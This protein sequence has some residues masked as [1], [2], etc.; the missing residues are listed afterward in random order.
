MPDYRAPG[1]YIEE[2]DGGSAPI[3]GASTA[4]AAF[5]GFTSSYP[6][7]DEGDPKALT[8]RKINNW[9]QFETLYGGTRQAEG[10][11]MPLAVYGWF[12]N[13]GGPAYIV[14]V[15]HTEEDEPL[16]DDEPE[17][18]ASSGDE[19][20]DEA[21]SGG[22]AT[23]KSV[24]PADFIG[25]ASARTGISGLVVAE[26]AT[27]V[28]CP[29]LVT[30]FGDEDG[31]L[32]A[33]GLLGF[34]AV[35]DA[36]MTQTANSKNAMAILDAP[37]GMDPNRVAAWRNDE[38]SY[39]NAFAALY[40]PWIKVANP[41]YQSDSEDRHTRSPIVTIPPS[42][43][44]AGAWA[45]NDG[46]RGPWKSP[47][48]EVVR[49]ALGLESQ[50][51]TLDQEDLNPIGVNC[52]RPFG[53]EGTKIWGARTLAPAADQWRYIA[54]RRLFNYVETSI[55][56]GTNWVVFEPNDE[57]LWARVSRTITAFLNGVWMQGGLAGGTADQAFYVKC[58][59]ETN[60]QDSIDQ[61]RLV[62][63]IG[64]APLKPAEFVIFRVSQWH[65]GA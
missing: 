62:C 30:A 49:G 19:D 1:V 25:S 55:L 61:G 54:V 65:P 27:M 40:Y 10:L 24:A 12:N 34:Q 18:A 37:P 50:I 33:D 28:M 59:A 38:A 63:E 64:L 16:S 57:P 60:P 31:N 17:A 8:P 13:G 48:N 11:K 14:R 21:A 53:S 46:T 4:V 35:Q 32:D 20:G 7:D 6:T 45:R 29:D 9:T 3:S 43:H 42:G 58:D 44:I 36:M 47:A 52:I 41:W 39:N 15:P 22:G 23:R 2:P 51:T 5:V 56:Q 26:D